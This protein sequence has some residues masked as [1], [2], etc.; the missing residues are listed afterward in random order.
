MKHPCAFSLAFVEFKDKALV[1]SLLERKEEVKMGD[2]VL[3]VDSAG[4]SNVN[5]K[6]ETT[7]VK[8]ENKKT[9]EKPAGT[10]NVTSVIIILFSFNAILLHRPV[11]LM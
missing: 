9:K 5:K 10:W 7:K 2:R 4:K 6:K 11:S 1:T 8:K 3:I